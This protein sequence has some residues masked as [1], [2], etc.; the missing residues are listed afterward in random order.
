MVV[1][2]GLRASVLRPSIT[3]TIVCLSSVTK[4]SL[5]VCDV[6]RHPRSASCRPGLR[7]VVLM[8]GHHLC[9][10][11]VLRAERDQNGMIE[12]EAWMVSI[13]ANNLS[14][15]SGCRSAASIPTRALAISPMA[16][17]LILLGSPR[18]YA[19]TSA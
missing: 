13:P 9:Q 19:H 3:P 6:L 1:L 11:H 5:H 15:F 17:D 8:R 7:K 4:T 12:I 16:P 10:R 2:V 14:L 18:T